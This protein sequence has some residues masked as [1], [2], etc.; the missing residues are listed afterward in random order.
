MPVDRREENLK[1]ANEADKIQDQSLAAIDRIKKT[2]Y[3]TEAVGVETLEE[4]RKQ[5]R[6]IDDLN[7][8]V[9]DINTKLDK[10]IALQTTFDS[11][12]GNWLG[13]KK[14]KAYKDAERE[15]QNAHEKSLMKVKEVFEQQNYKKLTRTWGDSKLVL[16]SN[17]TVSADQIFNP[18]IQSADSN[19]SVDYTMTNIDPEGWTY[20]YDFNTLDKSPTS[21]DSTMKWNSYVRRR[22][23][24]YSEKSLVSDVT[25]A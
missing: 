11:W 8:D 24:K 25:S 22:K 17:T 2:T 16:C 4:L 21:G 14:K 1:V 13:G 18:A 3:E 9:A 20:G 19:W 12:A 7:A 10:S 23:W 6:Q 5:A 15:I